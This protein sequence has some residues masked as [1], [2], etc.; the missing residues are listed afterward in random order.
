M[1]VCVYVCVCGEVLS[2]LTGIKTAKIEWFENS[3][4]QFLAQI[5]LNSIISVITNIIKSSC[6]QVINHTTK[7]KNF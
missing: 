4:V 5:W 7:N 6:L 3:K 1:C 2:L